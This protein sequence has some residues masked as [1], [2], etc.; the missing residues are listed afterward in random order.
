MSLNINDYGL[1]DLFESFDELNWP[2]GKSA[3]I[4]YG[5]G[6]SGKPVEYS[7]KFTITNIP[8]TTDNPMN[9]EIL[10]HITKVIFHKPA[11]IV[12]FDDGDKV[13]VKTYKDN[14]FNP[15]AGLALCI[16]KK[17]LGNDPEKFHKFFKD[18]ECNKHY[19]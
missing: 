14:K 1:A 19:D 6:G 9:K 2:T 7:E 18:W 10:R 4:W 11:T 5:A 16:L 17:M 15:E 12:Y 3:K 8:C 13:V